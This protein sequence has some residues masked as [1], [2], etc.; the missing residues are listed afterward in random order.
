MFARRDQLLF[1]DFLCVAMLE[2][3]RAQLLQQEDY[4]VL[5]VLSKYPPIQ[6]ISSI[7]DLALKLESVYNS[8]GPAKGRTRVRTFMCTATVH[9]HTPY[10]QAHF[11]EF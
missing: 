1:V 9:Y 3:V 10:T 8:G 11:A 6:V 7:T 2:Y 4:M 5:G